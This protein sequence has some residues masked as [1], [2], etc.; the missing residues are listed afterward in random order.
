MVEYLICVGEGF[1]ITDDE[2]KKLWDEFPELFEDDNGDRFLQRVNEWSLRE[3]AFV[4]PIKA[5]DVD[6]F[7]PLSVPKMREV[8]PLEEIDKFKKWLKENEEK[9]YGI[10]GF[11]V[12]FSTHIFRLVL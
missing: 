11:D 8:I 4:G 12:T 2:Y 9:F 1:F 10:C 6:D 3:G 7:K 5:F